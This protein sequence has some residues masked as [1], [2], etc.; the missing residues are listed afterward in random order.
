MERLRIAWNADEPASWDELHALV[1]GS[2]QQS[3][4]YGLV[5]STL[6]VPVLRATV[7]QGARL[8]GAGQFLGQRLP[9]FVRT[10]LCSRGPLWH[11][12]AA[13]AQKVEAIHLMRSTLPLWRPRLAIFTPEVDHRDASIQGHPCET[14]RRIVTGYS[15]VFVDLTQDACALRRGLDGNWRNRLAAAERGTLE[16]RD[17]SADASAHA[18]IVEAEWQ[19]RRHRGYFSLPREFVAS[20]RA[21]STAAAESTLLLSAWSSGQRVAAMLFLLHGRTATYHLGW[22]GEAGRRSHAHN[23]ILW[24]A[25]L[26]LR[27]RGI[28]VL[29]LGGVQTVRE[30][31]IARFKIGTGGRV[32][33]LVGSFV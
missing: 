16:I 27:Q 8:L 6:G 11:P 31:G 4:L 19:Q 10:A 12:A 1:A 5:M 25:L 29:D 30:P 26:A 33:T 14:L 3:W 22:A 15:T 7:H 18:Q 32:C 17:E 9:W 20:W 28:D 21:A 13:A 2:L 24:R 23:L